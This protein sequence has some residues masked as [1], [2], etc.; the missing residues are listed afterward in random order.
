MIVF[1]TKNGAIKYPV[2]TGEQIEPHINAALATHLTVWGNDCTL[3]LSQA[4]EV[5]SA[6]NETAGKVNFVN[7]YMEEGNMITDIV[8]G[9]LLHNKIDAFR[10]SFKNYCEE[11]GIKYDFDD[12]IID[13][14]REA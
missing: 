2:A 6:I 4:V 8:V 14:D 10:Y 5:I 9:E 7:H 11:N 12:L 1:I 3:D 13:V